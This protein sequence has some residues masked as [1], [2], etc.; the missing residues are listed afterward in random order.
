MKIPGN[1]QK[2]SGEVEDDS[3]HF[4]FSCRGKC[5]ITVRRC[6][7]NPQLRILTGKD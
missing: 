7:D 1:V 6:K 4:S 3:F 2:D 5:V